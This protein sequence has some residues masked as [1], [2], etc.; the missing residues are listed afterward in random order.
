MSDIAIKVKTEK[1]VSTAGD[2]ESKIQRLEQAFRSIEQTM[3]ASQ[4][5]W[6][7]EGASAQMNAYRKK[8]ETIQTALK[9]FRENVTDL[10][11]IAGIYE[12]NEA[13]VLANNQTLKV[14]L[15]I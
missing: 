5:Y 4:V 1:L 6:Q 7:G 8:V 15:I 3:E 9:R 12:K 14:D 2:V 13:E 11:S 10:Q